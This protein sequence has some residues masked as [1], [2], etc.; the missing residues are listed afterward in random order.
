[1]DDIE[2]ALG[3]WNYADCPNVSFKSG[4]FPFSHNVG[5]VWVDYYWVGWDGL[6]FNNKLIWNPSV[7]VKSSIKINTY[8]TDTYSTNA[9]LSVITHELGHSLGL[10]HEISA[11]L[12]NDSTFGDESRFGTYG[13]YEPQE[14]D[15]DGVNYLY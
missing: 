15:E 12:M 6:C 11:V 8:Y 2:T 9:R 3:L 7:I 10:G 13:I 14:D 5:I 1:D 4:G